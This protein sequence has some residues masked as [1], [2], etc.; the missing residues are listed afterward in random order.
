MGHFNEENDYEPADLGGILRQAHKRLRFRSIP[1]DLCL[2]GNLY[3]ANRSYFFT[4]GAGNPPDIYTQIYDQWGD[5]SCCKQI[6]D[7]YIYIYNTI[8]YII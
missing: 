7:M 1:I 2:V 6:A 3:I 4:R 8:I 5:Y